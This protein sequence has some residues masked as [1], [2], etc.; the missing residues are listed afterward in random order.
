M[1]RRKFK[2][3]FLDDR[4]QIFQTLSIKQNIFRERLGLFF[5]NKD[6]SEKKYKIML[7]IREKSEKNDVKN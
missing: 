5:T 4:D 3:V 7:K 1:V 2:T 6:I